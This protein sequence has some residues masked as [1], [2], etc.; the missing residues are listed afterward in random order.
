MNQ[1]IEIVC[2][3]GANELAPEN[4]YAS[5]EHCIDWGMD[6]LELDVNTSRDG[7]M[8]VFHG[9]DLART[10]DAT[11][12]K[13]YELDSLEVDQLDCGSWFGDEFVGTRIPRLD[14]YLDWID[15]RIKLFLDVKWA[16]LSELVDLIKSKCLQD[17]CFFWFG[18]DELARQFVDLNSGLS[19]KINA[20][21]V[22]EV[23][24]ARWEYGEEIVEFAL[25]EATPELIRH[26]R[27]VGVKSMILHKQ[28][29]PE[30]FQEIIETG[31]DMVNVDHGDSF[32][33]VRQKALG[34]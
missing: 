24:H 33:T 14:A 25:S 7:V 21:T 13:I 27:D 30:A 19:I 16:H 2:H 29:D 5:A 4:T 6:Y 17:D 34:Y 8:Y 9:P 3:R 12:G 32:L 15:R 18:S 31:V 20:T 28:N 10:T 11:D 22:D 26:C 1:Q 23:D